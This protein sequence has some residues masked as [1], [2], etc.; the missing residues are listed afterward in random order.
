VFIAVDRAREAANSNSCANKLRQ[1]GVALHNYLDKHGTFPPAF[2]CD[3]SGKPVNSWRT[4]VMPDLSYN[5]PPGTRDNPH[6]PEYDYSQPWNGPHNISMHLDQCWYDGFQC[7]SNNDLARMT[8]DYVAVV[9]PNTMWPGCEPLKPAADGSDKDKILVI[10][11]SDSDVPWI[12][13]RD[14]TLDEALDSMHTTKGMRIGSHDPGGPHYLTVA[15]EVRQLD[16]NIDRESLRKLLTRDPTAQH[17]PKE[18]DEFCKK[19]LVRDRGVVHTPFAGSTDNWAAMLLVANQGLRSELALSAQQVEELAALIDFAYAPVSKSDIDLA[20]SG[21]ESAALPKN[22]A[23]TRSSKPVEPTRRD[24]DVEKR[25]ERILN[26]AQRDHLDSI[27]LHLDGLMALE[28]DHIATRLALTNQQRKTIANI[29]KNQLDNSL[30]L[31]RAYFTLNTQSTANDIGVIRD[32][33]RNASAQL[34]QNIAAYLTEA[35][36]R[37]LA[38]I[39]S[40]SSGLEKYVVGPGLSGVTGDEV[41]KAGTPGATAGS[42][43][44]VNAASIFEVVRSN[45]RPKSAGLQ[46]AAG[47]HYGN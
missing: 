35:Q 19:A 2:I 1:M 26:D 38:T 40:E 37:S 44:S 18:I 25:I 3:E 31:H 16:P 20:G 32:R 12:E 46:L 41:K 7:P 13:P 14:L 39:L 34:D 36:L 30:G 21:T 9:G 23:K 15:G 43:S 11:V 24:V 6:P 10:E 42:S 8:T 4:R 17:Q 22:A 28:R 29:T 45:L 27:Y 5:F 33:L 47:C